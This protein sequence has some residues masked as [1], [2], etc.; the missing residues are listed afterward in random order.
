VARIRPIVGALA[1]VVWR[2]QRRLNSLV[3]NN[4]FWVLYLMGQGGAGTFVFLLVGV[5]ALFPLCADPFRKLPPERAGTWPVTAHDLRIVRIVSVFLSP[6][7]WIAM[8]AIVWT[9]RP[10]FLLLAVFLVAFAIPSPKS[11]AFR[12]VP[13]LFGELVRK[14]VRELLHLLD[15]Y[16][17]ML[18]S[19]S[20]LAYRLARPNLEPEAMLIM[21]LVVVVTFSTC[22]QCLFAL[23]AGP[24]L[25]RYRLLPLRGWRVLAAKHAALSIVAL[26]LT[27]P[28]H[29]VAAVAG[30]L[31][32]MAIGNHMAVASPRLQTRWSL[33]AGSLFPGLFQS[34]AIVAA[35]LYAARESA[36]FLAVCAGAYVVS[37][38]IYGWRF[39][40]RR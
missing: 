29:P 10:Q 4:L 15:P 19:V 7:A 20:T 28:L 31:V 2:D 37:T 26:P 18:L 35:G 32:A 14:N 1:R 22:A 24:G 39:D 9:R 16:V 25:E 11:L 38:W 3:A 5:V 6:A 13:G 40:R 8:G 36:W 21:C 33:T 23:D 27:A 12:F 30:L 17:A 34:G